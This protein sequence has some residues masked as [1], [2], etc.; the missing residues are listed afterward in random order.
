M[1]KALVKLR[2]SVIDF[3]LSH[4]TL[5]SWFNY[6]IYENALSGQDNIHFLQNHLHWELLATWQYLFNL[7][8]ILITKLAG[9]VDFNKD[10][11]FHLLSAYKQTKNMQ[12]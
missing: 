2:G 1:E 10:N 9:E 5:Q 4:F 11:F 6:S 8:Y 7:C 12:P 3:V